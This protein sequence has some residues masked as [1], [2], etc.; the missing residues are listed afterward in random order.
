[1]AASL[2][3]RYS[4]GGFLSLPPRWPRHSPLNPSV[5][6]LRHWE[7][8]NLPPLKSKPGPCLP[9][10][11]TFLTHLEAQLCFLVQDPGTRA[12][13]DEYTAL[14]SGPH[15][16]ASFTSHLILS[17][18]ALASP[19]SPQKVVTWPLTANVR[20]CFRH[21]LHKQHTLW[22]CCFML[23]ISDFS[24][25]LLTLVSIF[26]L[27]PT[28]LCRFTVLPSQAPPHFHDTEV[29]SVLFLLPANGL[30]ANLVLG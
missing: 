13:L 19:R 4:A 26:F 11:V 9:C 27:F 16:A 14:L 29:F 7:Q 25:W 6:T 8:S 18:I 10:P 23:P 17:G 21:T 12:T 20:P 30:E 2:Q 3:V 28:L 24:K 22:Y 1:M 5:W 15:R